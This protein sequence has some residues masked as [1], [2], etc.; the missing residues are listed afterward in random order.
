VRACARRAS[1]PSFQTLPPTTLAYRTK[2]A[3][4]T[5]RRTQDTVLSAMAIIAVAVPKSTVEC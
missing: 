3:V 5:G 4:D 1:N 2:D